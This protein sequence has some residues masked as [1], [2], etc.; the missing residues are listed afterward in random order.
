MTCKCLGT[1]SCVKV[2]GLDT[3]CVWGFIQGQGVL[4][5]LCALRQELGAVSWF[6]DCPQLIHSSK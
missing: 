3:E 5:P 2:G 4:G 1:L 6:L